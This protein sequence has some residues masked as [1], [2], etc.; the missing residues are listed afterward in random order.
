MKLTNIGKLK[1]QARYNAKFDEF[2]EKSKEELK[3]I[4]N[5]QKMSSTDR[6]ALMD[7]T[8]YLLWEESQEA[9]KMDSSPIIEESSTSEEEPR[10][11]DENIKE[12]TDEVQTT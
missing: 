5:T 11:V 6:K 10:L 7:A 12:N 8:S 1:I 4:F 3:E 9:L 2:K